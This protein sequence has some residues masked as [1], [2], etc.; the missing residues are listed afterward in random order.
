[1]DSIKA[2]IENHPLGTTGGSLIGYIVSMSESLDPT[3]RF[4]ILLASTVTAVSVAYLW[5]MKAKKEY[6][7]AKKRQWSRKKGNRNTR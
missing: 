4:I 6:Y 1:M 2:A 3:L 7:N 5:F